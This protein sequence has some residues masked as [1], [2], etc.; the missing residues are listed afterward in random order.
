MPSAGMHDLIL[1]PNDYCAQSS[2]CQDGF[3]H[4]LIFCED[5]KTQQIIMSINLAKLA[6]LSRCQCSGLVQVAKSVF[7]MTQHDEYTTVRCYHTLLKH[8]TRS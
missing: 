7:P 5:V 2:S 1:Q 3:V 8:S 6:V 4:W